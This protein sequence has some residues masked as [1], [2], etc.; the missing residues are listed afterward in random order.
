MMKGMLYLILHYKLCSSKSGFHIM[1][2]E[3]SQYSENLEGLLQQLDRRDPRILKGGLESFFKKWLDISG[4]QE[5]GQGIKRID[6]L[7][8]KIFPSASA[9]EKVDNVKTLTDAY[10]KYKM[11]YV[12]HLSFTPEGETL[13]KFIFDAALCLPDCYQ[14]L[15]WSTPHW[16]QYTSSLTRIH[17]MRLR[18]MW[19]WHLICRLL[20]KYIEG[21]NGSPI[22]ADRGHDGTSHRLLYP[23]RSWD[24]LL[25]S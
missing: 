24:H 3:L 12:K 11:E 10:H 4:L 14:L 5:A 19:R 23:Q 21:D 8:Q 17:M 1:T 18:G 16:R 22:S 2:Q 13:G 6:A 20:T 15:L 25:L 9:T 7:L